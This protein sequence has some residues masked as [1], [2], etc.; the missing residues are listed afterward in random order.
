MTGRP[1]IAF[2]T[3]GRPGG[4]P[5]WFVAG[6]CDYLAQHADV[7]LIDEEP[8]RITRLMSSGDNAAV[9]VLATP[10]WDDAASAR[11]AIRA[12]FAERQPT[13]IVVTNPAMLLRYFAACR[14]ARQAYG[15]R[16]QFTTHSGFLTPTLT[17]L[18]IELAA[19]LAL[20]SADRITSVS[21]YTR[22]YWHGRYPWTRARRF[23][24]IHNGVS[25]PPPR[26]RACRT[27]LRVG[28]VGRLVAEKDP[29]LFGEIASRAHDC[30]LPLEF[31]VFGEGPLEAEIRRRYGHVLA[32]RGHHAVGD[33]Y[34][35]ID[36]LAMT[37]PIE[38]CP[39]ALLEAK[40]WA[41]PCVAAAVGGIPELITDGI[42]G[43]LAVRRDVEA[44]VEALEIAFRQYAALSANCLRT[45]E[46]FS[47][48]R[49]N[50]LMWDPL[51][52]ARS[53]E[54]GVAPGLS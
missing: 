48:A 39:L 22:R 43:L 23:D 14:A 13:W 9:Q 53:S 50:A 49:H 4:G 8:A 25:L 44:F 42:D 28:F 51:L 12:E 31:H 2:L 38:N 11:K 27:P 15:T 35:D 34:G 30:G 41:V 37:S 5:L 17:R 46:R 19:S 54:A 16:L 10:V 40:S 52:S 36:L 47:S 20:M 32:L 21:D 6:A 1:R 3:F 24:V 29:L 26:T 33:I 45:R 7:T 18:A